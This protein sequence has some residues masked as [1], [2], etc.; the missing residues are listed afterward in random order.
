[1]I[2]TV[3]AVAVAL[4]VS[5]LVDL[6]TGAAVPGRMALFSLSAVALLV[7]GGKRLA[8]AGL[9]R[10]AGTRPGELGDPADEVTAHG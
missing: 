3:A 7:L 1:V 9:Q 5:V 6:A 10:P 8:A 4:V 2:R